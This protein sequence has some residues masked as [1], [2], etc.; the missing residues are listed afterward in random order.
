MLDT[1]T[2][3]CNRVSFCR[4]A[5]VQNREQIFKF[6]SIGHGDLQFRPSPRDY[7]SGITSLSAHPGW[8]FSVG[9]TM[10]SW[11]SALRLGEVA[12]NFAKFTRPLCKPALS[13]FPFVH[14]ERPR[15]AEKTIDRLSGHFARLGR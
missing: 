7:F 15:V 3:Q 1:A 12:A 8:C 13:P 14:G 6:A 11:A 9:W 4:S 5:V 10:T 2:L